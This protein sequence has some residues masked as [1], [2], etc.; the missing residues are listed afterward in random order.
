MPCKDKSACAYSP[1]H[2]ILYNGKKALGGPAQATNGTF[3]RLS[4]APPPKPTFGRLRTL[5]MHLA[6]PAARLPL[7]T[8][9]LVPPLMRCPVQAE[10]ILITLAL[11]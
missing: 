7:P 3:V 4:H 10:H 1:V 2:G 9:R 6:T 8:N 5:R 11:P